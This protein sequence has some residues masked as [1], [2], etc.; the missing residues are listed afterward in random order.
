[1]RHFL[2]LFLAVVT[3]LC[4][5]ASGRTRYVAPSGS[6]AANGSSTL[7]WLT[8][9]HAADSSRAGDTIIAR[10]GTYKG[11]QLGWDN[12]QNGTPANPILFRAEPGVI[13]NDRNA[14]TA[15]GID[16]EG[17][18]YIVIDGFTVK[19]TLGTIT[20]AGLRAVTDTGAVFRNNVIDSCGTW[21][22][23]T[24]FAEAA[25]I[26]NNMTSRSVLQ[27]GIYFSNS[28]N[29]PVIRG[30]TV[31]SNSANGIHMNGD[32]SQGGVGVI[33]YA[34]VENNIIY[35]NG[36]TGGSGI[37]CDG[38]QNSRFQN[39]LLYN[40]HASGISL[41]Q[42]DA[43]Q[44]ATFDT[45]VNNTIVE[46]SDA[47]W[48]VNIKNGSAHTVLTNN[49]LYNYH[50]SHGSMSFDS[51]SMAGLA[52]DYNIVMDRLTR[53]DENTTL[54][55]L[56]WR[57]ATGQDAHSKIA[58]PQQLF[59]DSA[60]ANY[61]LSS[62]SPA[63]DAGTSSNA[64]TTDILG[65]PRPQNSVFDIGAYEYTNSTVVRN[66]SAASG[67]PA[68]M[69]SAAARCFDVL[70]R[71]IAKRSVMARTVIVEMKNDPRTRVVSKNGW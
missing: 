30:N 28:A 71:S 53:D 64:P 11:F 36:R 39:N 23:L 4:L 70:G 32:V 37:N 12:P 20:R 63:R 52:S 5:Q 3:L 19:N 46:A 25:V 15:D 26:E 6:D 21:G 47:R 13:I 40:N 68:L 49:I 8:L 50:S 41:Y 48:C 45:V 35:D 27:H 29:H 7:P 43:S 67:Q 69:P 14:K 22:I 60:T 54:T 66:L 10:A 18:S 55:L 1:M 65:T 51:A 24:G 38:V 59:V 56:Q 34:L 17:A 31:F 16:L 42:I 2:S 9:Q 57:A 58:T 44:P 33:R 62:T 61:R